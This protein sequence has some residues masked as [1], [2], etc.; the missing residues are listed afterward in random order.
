MTV[1]L[2]FINEIFPTE[3]DATVFLENIVWQGQPICPYCKTSFYSPIR[4]SKRY[5][6]NKCNTNFSVT[7]RTLFHRSKIDLRKWFY[8]LA[9]S[10]TSDYSLR[11]LAEQ[12]GITKD[13]VLKMFQRIRAGFLDNRELIL[14][15][16]KKIGL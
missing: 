7:V 12:L 1:S 2:E 5:H 13:S 8:C 16:Q 9:I 11:S 15:I 4:K 6:C 3:E 10:G 14:A